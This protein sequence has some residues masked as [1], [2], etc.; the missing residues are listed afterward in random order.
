M[1]TGSPLGKYQ[2]SVAIK[3][4]GKAIIGR[5]VCLNPVIP[6]LS[7]GILI[8]IA[9]RINGDAHAVACCKGSITHDETVV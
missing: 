7:C 9:I 8:C 2:A 3:R 1:K 6:L 5:K 4:N